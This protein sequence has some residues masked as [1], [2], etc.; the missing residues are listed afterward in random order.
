MLG[1]PASYCSRLGY[2]WYLA[3]W[4]LGCFLTGNVLLCHTSLFETTAV[5]INVGDVKRETYPHSAYHSAYQGRAFSSFDL[6]I[7]GQ[8]HGNFEKVL[9]LF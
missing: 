3:V 4:T 7:V 5:K 1:L 2:R 9:G 8:N 6:I